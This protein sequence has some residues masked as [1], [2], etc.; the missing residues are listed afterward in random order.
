[1]SST[2]SDNEL[3]IHVVCH[4][5]DDPGWLWTL[6]DYYMGT[7][8]CKFSVKRILDNM[9]VSLSHKKERKFS[10]VEM[11]FF[12]RWYDKQT[13]QIKQTVKDYIKEG[14]LEIING[15]WVMHDEAGSYY[16]HSID[17]MRIGLKFLKEEFNIT[18][19]IGW[20]IDPFGHSSATSHILK[21]MNFDKIVLTRIDYLERKDRINNHNLEFIYDPF[22]LG[23]EIFTHISYHHYN[24]RKILRNYPGDKKIVLNDEELKDVCEKFYEEM[25]E[26]RVGYRTNNILLYYGEDFA[27]NEADINYENI[28]MIM[29]YVNNNMKGKMKMIYSTPSQYF[30]SVLKSGVKFDKHI[31]YDFFPYADN[32]HCYWTGYFSSRANLKGL[33]KQLGL[34]INIINKLLFQIFMDKEIMKKN[35]KMIDNAIK[36][37]YLAREN[38]GVLQ[39]HDAVTGTS[40]EKTNKD[41]ENMAIIGVEK[42]KKYI[43]MLIYSLYGNYPFDASIGY[44][45]GICI[46]DKK[47]NELE[48]NFMIINPGLNNEYVFNYRIN[49]YDCLKESYEYEIK[50]G[51]KTIFGNNISFYDVDIGLKYSSIQFGLPLNKENLI[52]S[53]SISKSDK[54][55][56]KQYFSE[57]KDEKIS[58]KNNSLI[59]D[60]INLKFIKDKNEFSL[61]HG[62][63][64][65][66]DGSNSKVR[67][68][69]SNPDGAYIFAPCEDELQRYESINK[70]KSFI[71]Q[72]EYYTSIVLRYPN[73]YLIIIIKNDN[74]N[75]YT[76][77]IFDPIP[78][79]SEKAFN[80]L[81]VLDSNINNIN[82]EYSQPEI[83][84][85][86]QGINMLK[87]I[88]DTRPNYKYEITE[89][90]TSN[91]YPI[92]SVVSLHETE[93]E[94][95]M[96]SIYSDR[97]QSVG[98]IEKGQI[99]IIC[100]RFSTVD[101]WKGVGEPLYENS[102]SDR[103]FPVKHFISFDN[104]NHGNYF[105]KIPLL[106]SIES[107]QN[108]LEIKDNLLKIYSGNED[109]DI[110]FEVKKYGEIYAQI[111]NVYCDYFKGSGKNEEVIKFNLENG[112]IC[113]YN[114]NGVEKMKEIK[115]GEEINIKQQVFK[116]FLIDFK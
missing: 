49:N 63:Y 13:D 25:L 28:E 64:T 77:S 41:Y 45:E 81:L 78:R 66:Y 72:N 110:E 29:D 85:D 44:E 30:N 74:L 1:M 16:K 55:I 53:L 40:K 93:N 46:C 52:S 3:I 73:S 51:E 4:T 96:I 31:N 104:K 58:I 5:H 90:I 83:Y 99:Q 113:E 109:L 101:D 38:L 27:Y 95:N 80:Y 89:K 61:S 103:F 69:K 12:K 114:L 68:E 22:G 71:Q 76:E 75:I 7:D 107:V 97:A 70:N 35:K 98:V 48:N 111:G 88:K 24:P 60:P 17:N 23:Q 82:K 32:A 10:Y 15:G 14:R 112:K 43:Y 105:N 37:I 86:S 54:V 50:L 91:F 8:H 79:K 84:T 21:Q 56:K 94:N 6:D 92:T 102:S 87:R 115:N 39:H 9:V 59:F 33:I 62:Y 100:Q 2:S 26:E 57:I 67:P 108:N 18:P 20:F 34:Y 65:S 116:S 106:L 19:K 11:S 42:I 47:E 36:C